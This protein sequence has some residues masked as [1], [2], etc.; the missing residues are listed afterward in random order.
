MIKESTIDSHY[1]KNDGVGI[2]SVSGRLTA[3]QEGDLKMILMKAL[4]S[5]ERAVINFR[6]ITEIDNSCLRLLR[7][8]YCTSIHLKSPIIMTGIPQEY[9]DGIFQCN[10]KKDRNIHLYTDHS[11]NFKEKEFR[12]L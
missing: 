12:R 10:E 8:A 1:E 2:Y 7:N 6:D 11:L 4:Y 9:A 5:T 3:E